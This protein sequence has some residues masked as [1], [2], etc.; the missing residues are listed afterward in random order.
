LPNP[1]QQ[2]K[3][4]R[5]HRRITVCLDGLDSDH[6]VL[7]TREELP[8]LFAKKALPLIDLHCAPFVCRT[9]VGRQDIAVGPAAMGRTGSERD[10]SG[11]RACGLV[12]AASRSRN[13]QDDI[14]SYGDPD[15][16]PLGT[17]LEHG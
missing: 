1:L 12:N 16:S 15:F 11:V 5:L 4:D 17:R 7:V 3:K 13:F 6:V 10:H 2:I 14:E 8:E 9:N